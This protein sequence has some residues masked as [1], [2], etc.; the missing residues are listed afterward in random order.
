MDPTDRL[1]LLRVV[2]PDRS[3]WLAPGG[4][5]EAGETAEQ[6]LARELREELGLLTVDIGEHV[7]RQ[8]AIGA[9]AA[10]H[11]GVRSD[12]YLVRT[13]HFTP[14][15]NPEWEREL[16]AEC[17]WWTVDELLAADVVFAPRELP[18]L[19]RALLGDGVPA[20]PVRVGL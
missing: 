5:I 20:R 13:A 6:C 14:E 17:R 4:G 19:I 3:F 9:Y 11:D 16:V 18:E 12:Y 10:G 15:P 2:L 1:L 7:W 8:E